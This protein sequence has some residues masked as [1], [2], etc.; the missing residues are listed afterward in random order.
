MSTPDGRRNDRR[1]DAMQD[2]NLAE[3]DRQIRETEVIIAQQRQ[4]IANVQARGGPTTDAELGLDCL[5]QALAVL[6]RRR[7]SALA[8]NP[9]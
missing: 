2:D 9:L 1:S 8:A 6:K 4:L 7:Q 3:A 5:L